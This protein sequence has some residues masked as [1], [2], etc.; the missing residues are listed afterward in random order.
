MLAEIGAVLLTLGTPEDVALEQWL[1]RH[2]L[3]D[4]AMEMLERRLE[5]APPA[6]RRDLR[7]RLALAA[8]RH[9]ASMEDP[10]QR[11]ALL[12]RSEELLDDLRGPDALPL[13]LEVLAIGAG[14]LE[15]V[16]DRHR[17]GLIDEE[18]LDGEVQSARR[19][20][21]R[22]MRVH[23]ELGGGLDE[24]HRAPTPPGR[25]ALRVRRDELTRLGALHNRASYLLGWATLH[26]HELGVRTIRLSDA[27]RRFESV[28]ELPVG[29]HTPEDAPASLRAQLPVGWAMIG[30]AV[31]LAR[32]DQVD[33]A[34]AWLD[35]LDDPVVP[36]A[37]ADAV[38][39]W[40]LQVLLDARR[41]E[42]AT[43]L[44][45]SNPLETVNPE[46]LRLAARI[47]YEQDHQPLVDAAVA[48][49][50][51]RGA[52]VHLHALAS[53][54]PMDG[55]GFPRRVAA[56]LAA[57]DTAGRDGTVQAWR[58]AGDRARAALA[59]SDGADE[60]LVRSM[61]RLAAWAAWQRQDWAD[62]STHFTQVMP[63]ADDDL[64]QE[65][66]VMA[67]AARQRLDLPQDDALD[68][69][70]DE[71]LRRFPEGRWAGGHAVARAQRMD[72]LDDD[73]L[74]T[75]MRID[76]RDSAWHIAG[77]LVERSLYERWTSAGLGPMRLAACDQYLAWVLPRLASLG[78]ADW[79]RRALAVALDSGDPRVE[80]ALVAIDHLP[81]EPVGID[82]MARRAHVA[83]L[84][85]DMANAVRWADLAHDRA[86]DSAWSRLAD[87][88]VFDALLDWDPSALDDIRRIGT[89]MLAVWP[90]D[91]SAAADEQGAHILR[92]LADAA[93]RVERHTG[94][95][96]DAIEAALMLDRLERAGL[97]DSSLL[98]RRA[99]LAEFL[100]QHSRAMR[101]WTRL[102]ASQALGS[103]PWFRSQLGRLTAQARLD[104]AAALAA[105]DQL[106]VL[107][108]G[109]GPPPWNIDLRQLHERL[110]EEVDAP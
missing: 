103:E 11:R 61:H 66:I 78:D 97:V 56:A 69:L 75:L 46:R 25:Q 24:L 105:L 17:L 21:Q 81:E 15:R 2:E 106:A 28:I 68:S 22:L 31:T 58:V 26:A 29:A 5:T 94:D 77:R 84:T 33:E 110:L 101:L 60:A 107:Y 3:G 86:G 8:A 54:W 108:P 49:L 55:D 18:T 64:A 79:A 71:S 93:W 76:S 100:A 57:W 85:G 67:V 13:Q 7:A 74:E 4:V 20:R 91:A 73:M 83:M 65:A 16:A 37:V 6:E 35:A 12:Y 88:Q 38:L 59:Q 95:R 72:H 39:R 90:D 48:E 82:D 41:L 27:Q 40:R 53:A 109:L 36:E 10:G 62:A 51:R 42:Q 34:L 23:Q 98:A 99:V 47:G 80:A 30:Q 43:S 9:L 14:G 1:V 44:L 63:T 45:E 50:A 87:R 92:G 70:L 102:A 104:R 52:I 19:L 89:R 96:Q 32:Q